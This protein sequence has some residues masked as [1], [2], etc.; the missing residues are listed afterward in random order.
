MADHVSS[1]AA[2]N[3]RLALL[4]AIGGAAG[5]SLRWLVGREWPV[6]AGEIP[7]STLAVNV[8]GCVAIGVLMIL[9]DEVLAGRVNVRPLVGVGLLGGFTTFSTFAVE[10]HALISA[11]AGLALAYFVAT[12]ILAV[13]GAIAGAS[14]ASSALRVRMSLAARRSTS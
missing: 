5:A 11:D 10:T 7:W 1:V 4:I 14:L 6:R 8:A 2:A 3:A 12:P 9:L 13:V